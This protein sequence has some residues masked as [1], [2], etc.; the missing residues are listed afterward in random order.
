MTTSSLIVVSPMDVVPS[1]LVS[2]NV[3]ENDY[4][5]WS[6]ATNYSKGQRV[7]VAAQHKVYQSS[8]DS[9]TNH[10]PTEVGSSF[11]TEV[12]PTNRWKAFD[13]SNSTQTARANLISYRLTPGRAVTALSALNLTGASSIRIRVIDPVNGTLYDKTTPLSGRMLRSTW[14]D[15][16]FGPRTDPKLSIASDLPPAPDADILIDIEGAADLAVGVILMGE[17]RTFSMGV[18]MGARVGIQDYSRKERNEFGDT[19]L[20]ERAFARRANFQLKLKATEVDAFYSF[21]ADVRATPCLW[22]GSERFEATTV[23]G[24][25]KSFEIVLSY[26]DYSDCDLELE[27]LT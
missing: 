2:T 20:V 23:Y 13:K 21:L 6:N 22:I 26:F 15:W 11:W 17:L 1:M 7:I 3:L 24:I 10:S 4:A 27:G 14:W 19:I 16:F 5:E 8:A 18:Q 25:Y 12:S 9:N